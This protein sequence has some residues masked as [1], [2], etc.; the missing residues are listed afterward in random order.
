M[1]GAQYL[2]ER[3]ANLEGSVASLIDQKAAAEARAQKAEAER[4]ELKAK[5]KEPPDAPAT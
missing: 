3:I 5:Q 1:T 2:L 4:D